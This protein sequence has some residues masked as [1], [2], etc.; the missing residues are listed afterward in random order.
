MTA[1][2]WDPEDYPEEAC[3]GPCRC[4]T[5]RTDK[6]RGPGLLTRIRTALR[7]GGRDTSQEA[8]RA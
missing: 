3:T 6:P 1:I 2:G 8:D 7:L 4:T 5:P